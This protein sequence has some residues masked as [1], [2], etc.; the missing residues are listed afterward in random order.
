MRKLVKGW[1]SGRLF[2]R[3]C[4]NHSVSCVGCQPAHL[5]SNFVGLFDWRSG[6]PA[7]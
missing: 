6:L 7:D 3:V 5:S 1:S 4:S 2:D